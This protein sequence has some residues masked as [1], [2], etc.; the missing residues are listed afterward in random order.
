MTPDQI[1]A[2]TPDQL[3]VKCAEAMGWRMV[4]RCQRLGHAPNKPLP[5][6][7]AIPPF[8]SDPR[9]ALTLCDHLAEKGWRIYIE[10]ETQG[11][12]CCIHRLIDREDY[13]QV[14][15]ADTLPLA[16]CKAFL[17]VCESE[18]KETR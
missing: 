4:G 13:L 17:T 10:T 1:N 14:G 18:G 5:R 8:D 9:A 3:R 11:W 16:I 15:A 2:L 12:R 7:R 6:P